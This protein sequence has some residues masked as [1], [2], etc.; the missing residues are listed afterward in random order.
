MPTPLFAA[1]INSNREALNKAHQ[2]QSGPVVV[3][4]SIVHFGLLRESGDS[5]RFNRDMQRMTRVHALSH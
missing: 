2:S 3:E 4:K 5:Q 1:V